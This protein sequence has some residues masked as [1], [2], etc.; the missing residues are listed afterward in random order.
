[1]LSQRLKSSTGH[2]SES[3]MCN[4]DT[5]GVVLYVLC[6]GTLLGLGRCDTL[7]GLLAMPV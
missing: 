3:I 4:Y 1:M 7:I 2:K 6:N 5:F